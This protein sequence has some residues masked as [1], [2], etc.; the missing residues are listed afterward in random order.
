EKPAVEKVAKPQQVENIDLQQG[1]RLAGG[2]EK[3]YHSVLNQFITRY[4]DFADNFEALLK[5]EDYPELMRLVHS[6]K[7][8][9]ATIGANQVSENSASL[10]NFL[11]QHS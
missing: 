7:G 5:E 8:V 4:K 11:K 9:S 1:L 10:E 3:L 6:L 2:S